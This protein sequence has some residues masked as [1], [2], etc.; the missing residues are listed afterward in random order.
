MT[1]N[2]VK[3]PKCGNEFPINESIKEELK[4][5]YN[6]KFLSIKSDFDKKINDL[7]QKEA[8]FDEN[9]QNAVNL[10]LQKERLSLE[11]NLK[12]KFEAENKALIETLKNDLKEQ[13]SKISELNKQ[14]AEIEA[15]KRKNLELEAEYKAK[16]EISLNEKLKDEKEKISKQLND[17]NELKFKEFEKQKDDLIKQINELKRKSELTS[18]QLQGEVMELAIEEFLSAK[19][20][21][22]EILE[23]KK[24][25]NGADCEHIVKNEFGIKC[26]KIIY[27]SK[28]TKNFGSDWIAKLKDDMLQS[29]ADIGVLVTQTMP[30]ELNRMGLMDGVWVCSFD[31]FKG[32]CAVLRESIIKISS[33]KVNSQNTDLKMGLLY[34][35]LTSNKFKMQVE[36]VVE[37]FNN[38]QNSLIKEQNAMKKI[39]K[40]REVAIEKARDSAIDMFGEIKGIAGESVASVESLEIENILELKDE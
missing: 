20:P 34:K 19:F 27:E 24:G 1:N 22:D 14:T 15:L 11:A 37:S 18:Q 9:L 6:A 13:S 38:M 35:Y 39:W 2:L 25:V 21:L 4:Q 30:K 26:G 36:M 8:K 5:E 17:E 33:A 12:S 32:L 40:E 3:C 23:V 28:R 7:K 31:E 16:M 10:Q 29:S